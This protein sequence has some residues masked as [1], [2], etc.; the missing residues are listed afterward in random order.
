MAIKKY[1]KINLFSHLEQFGSGIF[2]I[3][4]HISMVILSYLYE[5]GFI[6]Y[7]ILLVSIFTIIFFPGP[8]ILHF[9]YFSLN[10]YYDVEIIDQNS[11]KIK[12]KN[13]V[14]LIN[15][16]DVFSLESH[17]PA[18]LYHN[19]PNGFISSDYAYSRLELKDG[20]V[21]YLT[22]LLMPGLPLPTN[23]QHMKGEKTIK[24]R[25]AYPKKERWVEKEPFRLF[26]FDDD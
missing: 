5:P 22:S 11:M 16:R 13:E 19:F 10:K 4:V 17:L 2:A 20:K 1:Y 7:A 21:F 18:A 26:N 24:R 23:I 9:K 25:L 14:F 12:I 6:K 3:F 8:L 15:K